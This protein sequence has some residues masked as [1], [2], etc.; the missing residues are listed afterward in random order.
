MKKKL[1]ALISCALI[2]ALSLCLVGCSAG[3]QDNTTDQGSAKS[4]S[5]Q[6]SGPENIEQEEVGFMV[7]EWGSTDYVVAISNPNKDV[8]AEW[9]NVNIVGYDEEDNI[10]FSQDIPVEWIFPGNKA[11]VAGS[12]NSDDVERIECELSVDDE[13]WLNIDQADIPVLSIEKFNS[14]ED[15]F[16]DLSFTGQIVN[17]SEKDIEDA[18]ITVLCR[19]ADGELITGYQAYSD[20]I[21][22][23]GTKTFEI[24][25]LGNVAGFDSAEAYVNVQGDIL[26]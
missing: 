2:A 17:E 14:K 10:A 26:G 24:T 23:G 4:G 11:F 8:T 5:S 15:K 25:S 18:L 9:P 7:N 3:G 13:N 22:A 6:S 12:Y 20:S 19:D 1:L 21:P 16:G